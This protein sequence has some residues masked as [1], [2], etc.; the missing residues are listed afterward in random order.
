MPFTPFRR[1]E[2]KP[3]ASDDPRHY[4]TVFECKNGIDMEICR[5]QVSKRE[6]DRVVV[7]YCKKYRVHKDQVTFVDPPKEEEVND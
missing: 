4:V 7:K 1:I 3:L 5:Q 6:L 2:V